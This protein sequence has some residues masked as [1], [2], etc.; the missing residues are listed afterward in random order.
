MDIDKLITY[1]NRFKYGEDLYHNLMQK[2]VKKILLISTFYNAFVLEEESK[3]S[4]QIIGGYHQFNLT[5]IP[6]IKNAINASHALKITEKEN[7]DLVIS[8]LRIGEPGPFKLAKKIKQQSPE[9]SFT[10]LFTESFDL[11]FLNNK[12]FDNVDN[13][14]LWSGD[15]SLFLSMIKLTEDK[16]NAASDTETGGVTVI[17]LVEDSINFYSIYLPEIYKIL[18]T[19][20][21]K[22]IEEEA[23][24]DIKY[25]RMRT[26]PKILL[27]KNFLEAKFYF[28]KYKD[29]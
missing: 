21:Q 7:F 11:K 16:W 17:L 20:T 3:F 24:N 9:T 28:E 27:A 18:M 14:F 26:R 2:R 12:H 29:Y 19:Q 8:T 15:P 13:T 23:N 1:Y 25:L 6:K 10:L 4:E 5:S 22:L